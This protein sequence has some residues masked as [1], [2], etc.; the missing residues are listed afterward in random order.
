MN[1]PEFKEWRRSLRV[2]SQERLAQELDIPARSVFE[3][4][5]HAAEVKPEWEEAVLRVYRR[6]LPGVGA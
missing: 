1:G 5:K 2:V 6:L 3:V 4:E